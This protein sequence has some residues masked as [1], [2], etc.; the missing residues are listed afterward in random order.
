MYRTSFPSTRSLIFS[1]IDDLSKLLELHIHSNLASIP[2]DFPLCFGLAITIGSSSL[3]T[4][5]GSKSVT[6]ISMSSFS[7]SGNNLPSTLYS[8]G[9]GS[10]EKVCEN[11]QNCR[12]RTK[13]D[14]PHV[15]FMSVVQ[16]NWR[17]KTFFRNSW[18]KL[19]LRVMVQD[20]FSWSPCESTYFAIEW[21]GVLYANT[22]VNK[23]SQG[24]QWTPVT[25]KM[26]KT[27][28]VKELSYVVHVF[29]YYYYLKSVWS[30][31]QWNITKV[32]FFNQKNN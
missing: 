14:I 30:S 22:C 24:N 6:T 3:M 2:Q 7:N 9:G 1:D 29:F 32:Q 16:V 19:P 17:L 31:S 13:N 11:G 28:T 12:L 10:N 15:Q 8:F 4:P 25:R 27:L 26:Q 5:S 21:F 23:L 18:R 20:W